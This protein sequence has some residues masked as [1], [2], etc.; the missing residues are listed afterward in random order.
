MTYKFT[1]PLRTLAFAAAAAVLA[2]LA[3]HAQNNSFISGFSYVDRDNDGQLRF[4]DQPN[5]ERII[6]GVTIEL[7]SIVGQTQTL[8][9]TTLTDSIGQY[10]F[11]NLAA[12]TYGVKQIQ[13]VEFLDGINSVGV[14]HSLAGVQNPPGSNVGVASTANFLSN[15][16]LPANSQAHLYNFGEL[17]LGPQWASKRELL[18][19]APPP[20]FVPPPTI[21]PEPASG[22]LALFVG[23]AA[24]F[25]R[26]LS[27]RR[28][29]A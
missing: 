18:G 20:T 11:S 4:N 13:P 9:S 7:Y 21:I 16:V 24:A 6:P 29:A 27:T 25:R 26:S 19:S 14:I 3:T 28:S 12:G 5:P 17:G 1:A 10:K 2:P 22:V 23:M 8:L 15:I